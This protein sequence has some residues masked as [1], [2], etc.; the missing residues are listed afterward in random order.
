M[1]RRWAPL[2]AAVSGIA[3]TAA[4]AAGVGMSALDSLELIGTAVGAA[5]TA[6]SLCA[7]RPFFQKSRSI[8]QAPSARQTSSAGRENT[9]GQ[10]SGRKLVISDRATSI[11]SP[12]KRQAEFQDRGGATRRW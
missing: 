5:A 8:C 12:Y 10:N 3:A 6:V 2:I 4:V 1:T 9:V 11:R 7:I